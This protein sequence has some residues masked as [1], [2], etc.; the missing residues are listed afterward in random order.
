MS[1][2]RAA[3]PATQIISHRNAC[4]FVQILPTVIRL[5]INAWKYVV[6]GN[7]PT[8]WFA[9]ERALT[10]YM[11]TQP[12]WNVSHLAVVLIMHLQRTKL[13]CVYP[14]A[15]LCPILMQTEATIIAWMRAPPPINTHLILLAFV[16]RFAPRDSLWT[17]AQ[18]N[19]NRLVI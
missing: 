10:R 17:T 11:A 14:T 2:C 1:V 6:M 8:V 9:W 15:P 3:H 13:I 5:T 7:S 16:L 4:Q 12:Q 19:A 18:K